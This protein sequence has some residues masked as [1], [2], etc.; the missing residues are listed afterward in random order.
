[1]R[2]TL[3][4]LTFIAAIALTS[5]GSVTQSADI[6]QS[7]TAA[8][9]TAAQTTEATT[10]A[11]EE[12]KLIGKKA[13]GSS[14]YT[15]DLENKTGKDI[16][17][18]QVKAET[19]EEYPANML[20]DKDSFIKNEKRTL[21]YVPNKVSDVVYGDS[22]KVAS[23]QYD[24]KLIFADNKEVVLHSF[25]FGDLDS[26]EIFLENDIAYIK[27]TSKL[28]NEKVDTKGAEEMTAKIPEST[29]TISELEP[30]ANDHIDA[31]YEEPD[32]T[33]SNQSPVAQSPV[34][35]APAVQTPTAATKTPDT[36]CGDKFAVNPD[37]GCGDKFAV[38]PDQGCGDKFAVNTP[39]EGCGSKFETNTPDEGCGSRF[40]TNF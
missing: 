30:E 38:N 3:A 23:L 33:Q 37:Q 20:E 25:P 31:H 1:M 36:G 39:D 4:T 11:A 40:A 10:K 15:L 12:L 29:E 18:F 22:D 8:T 16:K 14:V 35:Q 21:Y 34:Q 5:C 26:A 28:T 27:Y 2:K 7:T 19:E 9:T 32:N 17:S 13:T 24:I 6:P